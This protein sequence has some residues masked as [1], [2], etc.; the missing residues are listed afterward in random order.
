MMVVVA[1][2]MVSAVLGVGGDRMRR[3]IASCKSLGMRAISFIGTKSAPDSW[4]WLQGTFLPSNG[5]ISNITG[6]YFGYPGLLTFRVFFE[7]RKSGNHLNEVQ[8]SRNM[9]FLKKKPP[10]G[11][12]H[13]EEPV[14]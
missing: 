14:A 7:F 11:L 9:F 1:V 6:S 8:K 3:R 13:T 4:Y 12:H 2:M 10:A 5:S